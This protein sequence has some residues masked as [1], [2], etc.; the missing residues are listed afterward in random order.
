M[1]PLSTSLPSTGITANLGGTARTS[2]AEYGVFQVAPAGTVLIQEGKSH[3]RLF[4]VISG[5]FEARRK[6]SAAGELLGK[7]QCGEWI[8]E[9][10]IFDPSSPMCSVIASEPSHY[11]EIKRERLEEFLSTHHEAGIVLLIGLAS[12]LGRRI[13]GITQK[14]AEQADRPQGV[15]AR[16]SEVDDSQ[17]RSAADLAADFL[18]Q[19]DLGFK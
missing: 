19:K 8:G 3:G 16:A 1:P 11:W 6:K 17:I 18:R 5:T 15:A 13:R 4:C 12:T 10:D 14:L 2:L 9:V 7:I